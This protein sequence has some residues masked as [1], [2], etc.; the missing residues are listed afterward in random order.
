MY[1]TLVTDRNTL[2]VA[3]R[4]SLGGVYREERFLLSLNEI[5]F[6]VGVLSLPSV[7]LLGPAKS[8]IDVLTTGKTLINRVGGT[9]DVEESESPL[10]HVQ[11]T[12]WITCA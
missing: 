3:R 7:N 5:A 4:P 12:T 11:H 6:A 8:A 1:V 10:M 2:D 9:I